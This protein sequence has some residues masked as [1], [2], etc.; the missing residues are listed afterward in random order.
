VLSDTEFEL[1]GR[2]ED[3]KKIAGKRAS[4]EALNAE[5]RRVPGVEDGVFFDPG[6]SARLA[7]VVVA[8]GVAPQAILRALRQRIDAAF[9]P[10]PLIM[11]DALPRTTT[12]KVARAALLALLEDAR[13]RHRH[14]A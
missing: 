8:P 9:L 2:P 6:G 10:R 14:P 12:G 1:L 3:M 11:T 5:L 4:I 13:A 7:A